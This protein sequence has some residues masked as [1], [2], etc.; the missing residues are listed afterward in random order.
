MS[1][2]VSAVLIAKN[3]A[4][5]ISRCIK[6][7]IGIDEIVI[8]DTGSTDKT[9]EIARGLGAK[10][11]VRSPIVPFDFAVARNEATALAEHDWVITIDADEVIRPGMISKL[12]KAMADQEAK[13][14]FER[15]SALIVTFTDRGM[16][17]HKTKAFRKSCW[18]WK[19]RV[20]EQLVPLGTDTKQGTLESVV[21]EH[22][23]S[24]DKKA[25]HAQNI[26]LL[27]LCVEENPEYARAWRH[28][29]QEL[30]LEKKWTEAIPN[31]A[32]YLEKTGENELEKSE[33]CC[34]V[35]KCYAE[36]Y[37]LDEA[38]KWF[39]QAAKVDPRRREPFYHAAL[40]L[41]K[42]A[43][44]E[45]AIPWVEGMM[46]VPQKSKPG[47]R[48]DVPGAWG[49]DGVKMLAFCQAEIGRAKAALA[50][51]AI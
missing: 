35:G 51:K 17:T 43:R 27:K 24:P 38:I 15:V 9:V 40:A 13:D 8:L 49:A 16:T 21:F 10:V 37:L 31:L 19:Y 46:K 30:M 29:G 14:P 42:A 18:G 45:E 20:H 6:S 22:L 41:I 44:L 39:E 25:R 34:H 50:E 26:D 4:K 28:L 33:V 5:V 36:T 48:F 47:S 23:P 7:L 12:R 32:T 3:E 11:T 2:K 1:V